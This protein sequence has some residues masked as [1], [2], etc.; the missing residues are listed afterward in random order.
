MPIVRA[1]AGDSTTTSAEPGLTFFGLRTI[2]SS[3]TSTSGAPLRPLPL[4]D[5]A[6]LAAAGLPFPFAAGG[7][8]AAFTAFAVFLSLAPALSP[9]GA[10][11]TALATALALV[12][13]SAGLT[14]GF[15][16]F[17]FLSLLTASSRR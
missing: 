7:V 16:A 11:A 6:G 10:L 12:F 2:S 13:A 15:F 3:S 17:A 8:T 4:I 9:A 1:F 5:L 14:E